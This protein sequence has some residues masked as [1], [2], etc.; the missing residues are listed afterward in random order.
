MKKSFILTVLLVINTTF[1][2]TIVISDIDDTLKVAHIRDTSDKISTAFRT[3]NIFLGMSDVFEK[4]K[5]N[6]KD[7]KFFYLSNAPE[8][9]MKRSHNALINNGHFPK[10]AIILRPSGASSETHKADSLIKLIEKNKPTDVILF[11]DN[12]E[13]DVNFYKEIVA[14]YPEINFLTFIRVV[15]DLDLIDTKANPTSDQ[16]GFISPFEVADVLVSENII[17]QNSLDEIY[18]EH[19]QGFL[20]DKM[21]KKNGALYLPKWLSCKGFTPEFVSN[22]NE[23]AAKYVQAKVNSICK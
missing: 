13:H 3:S 16:H 19:A 14:K 17:D 2:S 23:Q 10:D 18:R 7:A 11:G 20:E 22:S 15:Y 12:G 1:A 6:N 9:L 21:N 8:F 5:L 4:I